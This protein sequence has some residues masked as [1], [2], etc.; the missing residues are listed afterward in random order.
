MNVIQQVI[1]CLSGYKLQHD[2]YRLVGSFHSYGWFP[3]S[4]LLCL[5]WEGA[6]GFK[7]ETNEQKHL[8]EGGLKRTSKGDREETVEKKNQERVGS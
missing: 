8:T 2:L 6:P 7:A 4:H 1:C 5:V 3:G